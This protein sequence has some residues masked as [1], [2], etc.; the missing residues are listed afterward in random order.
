M[1][2]AIAA[3]RRELAWAGAAGR[4][5]SRVVEGRLY[6]DGWLQLELRVR[7]NKDGSE[8]ERGPYWFFRY[9]EAGRQRNLYLGKTDH[10]E[11]ELV[12]RYGPRPRARGEEG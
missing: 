6:E 4:Q 10:P 8:T 9:H 3:R 5:T 2:R 1:E 12:S 11:G 7:R